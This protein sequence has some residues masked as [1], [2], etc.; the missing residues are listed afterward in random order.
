MTWT[1]KVSVGDLITIPPD[2]PTYSWAFSTVT[3]SHTYPNPTPAII[4]SIADAYALVLLPSGHR[5]WLHLSNCHPAR[6]ADR[7]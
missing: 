2:T 6:K 5:A 4:T 7:T 3:R 1:G